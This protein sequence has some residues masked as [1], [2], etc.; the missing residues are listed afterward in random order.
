M[1]SKDLEKYGFN[2]WIKI[3]KDYDRNKDLILSLPKKKGVYVIRAN[4][5]IP[6][7]KGA[8]DIVYIGQGNIQRRIQQLLRSYLPLNFRN[9]TSKHTA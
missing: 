8:S 2:K 5:L 4:K 1:F 7:I 3:V 9:Y 6:R